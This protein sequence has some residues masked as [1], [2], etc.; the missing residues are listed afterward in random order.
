[1]ELEPNGEL[2]TTIRRLG[3]LCS[4]LVK[5]YTA[6]LVDAI[7]YIHSMGIIHRDVKPENVLIDAERRLKI[8]DFG[9]AKL[10]EDDSK[11]KKDGEEEAPKPQE[12]RS[13]S[14]VGSGLYVSPELLI[15]SLAGK[16]CV[17][18]HDDGDGSC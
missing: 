9:S 10:I 17:S 7:A 13:S 11:I 2:L 15:Y 8:T 6:Q 4:A 3:S 16:R 18:S 14:F 5:H 1:M 12:E